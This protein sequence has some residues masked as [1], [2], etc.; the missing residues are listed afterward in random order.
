MAR[1]CRIEFVGVGNQTVLWCPVASDRAVV[2]E[3]GWSDILLAELWHVVD[4]SL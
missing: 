4:D 1:M 3:G 2:S